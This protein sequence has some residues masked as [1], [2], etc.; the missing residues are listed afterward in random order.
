[1]T[2]KLCI[3]GVTGWTG[4]AIARTVLERD[5]VELVSAV[6]RSSAGQDVGAALGLGRDTGVV[7]SASVDEALQARPDVFIDYTSATVVKDHALSA[8]KQGIPV[9]VGTSG[10]TRADFDDLDAAARAD[11]VG[12]IGGGNFSMTA[13]MLQYLARIAARHLPHYEILDFSWAD[14]E[15]VPS[16]TAR[17]LAETLAA[18]RKPEYAK[19]PADF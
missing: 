4:S 11:G 10:L 7:I 13:A 17:E 15:D 1:M 16:G 2:L 19:S 14:K 12:I 6:A 5:G 8:M 9:I 18:V 3:A